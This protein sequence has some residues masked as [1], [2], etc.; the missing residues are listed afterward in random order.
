MGRNALRD[1][2]QRVN[3][4]RGEEPDAVSDEPKALQ[5]VR[6]HRRLLR[7]LCA[8]IAPRKEDASRYPVEWGLGKGTSRPSAS[9]PSRKGIA[10]KIA[11]GAPRDVVDF[12]S[13]Q[14]RAEAIPDAA[15]PPEGGRLG[16][17]GRTEE[18]PRGRRDEAARDISKRGPNSPPRDEVV[19]PPFGRSL[20]RPSR[21]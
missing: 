14:F 15:T 17:L 9:E 19:V 10:G 20:R 11:S 7:L 5:L 16:R 13:R 3:F 1:S 8:A 12:E 18:G 2:L 4:T 6:H 21:S